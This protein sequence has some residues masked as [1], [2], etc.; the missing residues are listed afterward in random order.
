MEN[1]RIFDILLPFRKF[2][3]ATKEIFA[4]KTD[5][6]WQKITASNYTKTVDELSLGLTLT[7]L[8]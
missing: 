3:N 6:Q 4:A 1:T 2:E 5:G 7:L 8:A